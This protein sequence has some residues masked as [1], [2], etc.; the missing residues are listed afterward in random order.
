MK[1]GRT[2]RA[3]VA[4]GLVGAF[5]GCGQRG[6]GDPSAGSETKSYA[7]AEWLPEEQ[8]PDGTTI[9]VGNPDAPSTVH[10]YEDP[11]C[12]VVEE[13]ERTGAEAVR[14]LLLTGEVKAQYTFASFKD[15]RLGG[16][17]SKRAVNALRAALEK[18]KFVEYH[19]V[20]FANQPAVESS[21][22]FTTA[23][24]LKLA[25][26]VPGLRD[27]AFDRAVRTMKY[28]SFV[29]ASEEAYE[30]AGAGTPHG[31]RQLL[32][33]HRRRPVRLPL[34]RERVPRPPDRPPRTPRHLGLPLPPSQEGD[35][36][37][38]RRV[39]TAMNAMELEIGLY[40]WS[41]LPCRSCESAAHVPGEL[42]RMAR[43]RTPGE[44]EPRDIEFHVLQE[45][46][47][48]PTV[49]PVARV[50]MAG[51]A[52][53]RVAPVARHQFLDLLSSFVV[54]DDDDLAEA[55]KDAARA[56]IWSL[57]EE[58]LSGRAPG[59]A[60]LAYWVLYEVETVPARLEG[61]LGMARHLLPE[62]LHMD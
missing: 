27:E 13:Y 41:R 54:V 19:S 29:T 10:V 38:D 5:V 21:G 47:A 15:D 7:S 32:P 45:S 58:V 57:Y 20:L 1:I 53:P 33:H 31:R 18:D 59:T 12:P 6:S 50:L 60:L 48:T 51:L 17:G 43:A 8:D 2:V 49:V 25:E 40:D 30:Q 14:E 37:R 55:C 23:R 46:W 11:R 22:G 36:G 26:E 34:R 4:V 16:D 3:V 9:V 52:D 35:R 39:M 61:L 56:G 28:S 62:N 24:L 44:A 42:L